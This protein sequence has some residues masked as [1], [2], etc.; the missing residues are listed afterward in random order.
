MPKPVCPSCNNYIGELVG[1]LCDIYD[2]L[3]LQT[4]AN[5]MMVVYISIKFHVNISMGFKVI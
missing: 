3:D 5:L 2:P 4:S 1:I